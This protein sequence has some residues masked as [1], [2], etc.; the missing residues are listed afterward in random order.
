MFATVNRYVVWRDTDD[1][2]WHE[3]VE[4]AVRADGSSPA[5]DYL[6][7]MQA[8][9]RTEDPNYR[10]PADPE[11]IHDYHKLKAKIEHLGYYGD[12][13]AAS[14]VN[15]LEDGIWEL[16]HGVRRLTYWDTPGD[17]TFT[18]KPRIDDATTLPPDQQGRSWWWYPRMDAVLRLGCAWDKSGR[19]APQE[20]IAEALEMRREDANHD[21]AR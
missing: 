3:A 2:G 13:G 6:R 17:G 21:L 12:P 15:H 14:E 8:G 18:P 20:Q 5:Q 10:P 11:Q 7:A 4:C 1:K 19:T 16:K 9:A